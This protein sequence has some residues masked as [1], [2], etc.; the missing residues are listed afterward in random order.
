MTYTVDMLEC[1]QEGK[2][3]LDLKLFYKGLINED[4]CMSVNIGK[5]EHKTPILS[6]FVF[7]DNTAKSTVGA[8]FVQIFWKPNI[9]KTT[10]CL[11]SVKLSTESFTKSVKPSE[12]TP[13]FIVPRKCKSKIATVSYSFSSNKSSVHHTILTI[14][15]LEKGTCEVEAY[16]NTTTIQ[17]NVTTDQSTKT[18]ENPPTSEKNSR[19]LVIGLGAGMT[20][21]LISLCLLVI[22]IKRCTRKPEEDNEDN[23]AESI[24]ERNCMFCTKAKQEKQDQNEIYGVYYS[25]GE[26]LEIESEVRDLNPD[27][28]TEEDPDNDNSIIRDMNSTYGL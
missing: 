14:P 28:E 21:G 12:G 19:V 7:K 6:D 18:K 22:C 13:Y 8:K 2:F 11:D 10:K 24:I 16:E 25:A 27:Y 4:K 5:I 3:E 9:I 20:I 17:S 15:S 23:F 1:N 26:R